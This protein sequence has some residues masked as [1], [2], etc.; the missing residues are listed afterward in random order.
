MR[1]L[2]KVFFFKFLFGDNLIEQKLFL[3]WMDFS[4]VP[5]KVLSC[6]MCLVSYDKLT[7]FFPAVTLVVVTL[8]VVTLVVV[9]LVVV[10]FAVLTFGVAQRTQYCFYISNSPGPI[11]VNIQYLR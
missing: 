5:S 11:L 4:K 7:M 9:T 6:S 3:C 10:T 2:R 1:S 8:V